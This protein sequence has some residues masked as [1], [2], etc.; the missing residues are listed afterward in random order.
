MKRPLSV[1][2]ICII[3][4]ICLIAGCIAPRHQSP[5]LVAVS[6]SDN[7]I[8]SKGVSFEVPPH[9]TWKMIRGNPN[10]QLGTT[11]SPTHSHVVLLNYGEK[12][13]T[14]QSPDE[15]LQAI[16]LQWEQNI[17]D[18]RYD[19]DFS[20]AEL[21]PAFGDFC[22]LL[23]RRYR[24]KGA[25]N[26]GKEGYLIIEEYGYVFIHPDFPDEIIGVNYSERFA[27][28]EQTYMGIENRKA[29]FGSLRII[30]KN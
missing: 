29:L 24:D 6:S 11:T 16:K 21:D 26:R 13:R 15:F 5:S 14:Y 22:I 4:V 10:L 3:A 20:K 30:K 18:A 28:G 19:V 27:A 17:K 1:F 8:V 7:P 23:H 9:G 25:V 12:Q 2:V